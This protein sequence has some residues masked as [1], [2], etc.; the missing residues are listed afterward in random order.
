MLCGQRKSFVSMQSAN[1]RQMRFGVRMSVSD[2]STG[3]V[4]SNEICQNFHR[5]VRHP[6]SSAVVSFL[7]VMFKCEAQIS[8]NNENRERM[9]AT[10]RYLMPKWNWKVI[11][12]T[13]FGRKSIFQ[14]EFVWAVVSTTIMILCSKIILQ[15][16]P[17]AHVP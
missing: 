1:C 8:N 4:L 5:S 15:Q 7:F 9:C 2:A 16:N 17:S 11:C 12:L 13:Q 10:K 14:F 6:F 3:I